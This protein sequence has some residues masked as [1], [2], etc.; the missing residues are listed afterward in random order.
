MNKELELQPV[1]APGI[2]GTNLWDYEPQKRYRKGLHIKYP[3][4][5]GCRY[6]PKC[7]ACPFP[8][9]YH[10]NPGLFQSQYIAP[11]RWCTERNRAILKALSAG[12]SASHVGQEFGLSTNTIRR[13]RRIANGG[14]G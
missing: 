13:V 11:A 14:K 8:A 10:D 12:E 1:I 2:K 3:A 9:C 6:W 7:L 4:D 5:T